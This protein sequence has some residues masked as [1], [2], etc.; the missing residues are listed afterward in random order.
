MIIGVRCQ[1]MSMTPDGNFGLTLQVAWFANANQFGQINSAVILT[2][3]QAADQT[4][5]AA[6][7]KAAVAQSAQDQL[8]QTIPGNATWK[9]L[10]F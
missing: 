2:P 10:G 5:S 8:G 6:A 9:F 4:Q 3:A 1:N 7:I